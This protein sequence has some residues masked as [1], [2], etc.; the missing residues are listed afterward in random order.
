MISA[1]MRNNAAAASIPTRNGITRSFHRP[2]LS[3][4]SVGSSRHDSAI[5]RGYSAIGVEHHRRHQRVEDPPST[6]PTD[7]HR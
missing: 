1:G 6:P 5:T 4:S 3:M 7:I 2:G